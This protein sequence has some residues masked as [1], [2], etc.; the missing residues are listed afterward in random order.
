MSSFQQ[1][2]R[3]QLRVI[4]ALIIRELTTRFGRENIGF[5]WVMA[6]PL[7][8]AVLV[9]LLWRFQKGEMDHGVNIIAFVASGYLPFVMFRSAVN[10]AQGAFTANASL[11]YHR[12]VKILDILIVRFFVEMVG[13]LMAYLFIGTVLVALDQFPVPHDLGFFL[14]GWLYYCL[15]TLSIISVIAP[16][17]EMSEVLEKI[18][19]VSV[20][21]MIPFSGAFVMNSWLTPSFRDVVMLSPAVHGME[22]MRYGIFGDSVYAQYSFSYPWL[23]FAPAITL[24][25]YLCRRLRKH[26]VVE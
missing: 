19:P 9:G 21:I 24:G 3:I 1:G 25:L 5:L 18:L 2:A 6:E 10:R 26:M 16:L 11:L 14:I 20:Y 12:Q 13:H 17:S 22:M 23:F 15:F 7:L 8:F 4:Q